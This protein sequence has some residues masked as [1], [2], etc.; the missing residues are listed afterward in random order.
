MIACVP[1]QIDFEGLYFASPKTLK[2][3]QKD[4]KASKPL[5]DIQA[6]RRD[7]LKRAIRGDEEAIRILKEKYRIKSFIHRRK[8][9]I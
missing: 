7:L 8:V 6:R 3:I 9:I 4:K 5:N 2:S 1:I